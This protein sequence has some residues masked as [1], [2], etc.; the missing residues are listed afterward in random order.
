MST[1][2]TKKA[3]CHLEICKIKKHVKF[4][5]DLKKYFEL[6]VGYGDYSPQTE[7]GK[8]YLICFLFFGIVFFA[9]SMPEIG[10]IIGNRQKYV[11]HKLFQYN[12]YQ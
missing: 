7:A 9:N 12:D 4:Q 5:V 8:L 2:S 3:D 1:V 11:K 10:A 6:K